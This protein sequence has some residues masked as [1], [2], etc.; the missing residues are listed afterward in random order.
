M[1]HASTPAA[2][3]PPVKRGKVSRRRWLRRTAGGAGLFGLWWTG[4]GVGWM[5]ATGL[6]RLAGWRVPF[7]ISAETTGVIEPLDAWGFPDYAAAFN[8]QKSAGVA[9]EENFEEGF[10]AVFGSAD[11]PVALVERYFRPPGGSVTAARPTFRKIEDV[12]PGR[13]EVD[14]A[15]IGDGDLVRAV[16]SPWT[17]VEL[18]DMATWLD[19]NRVALDQLVEAC[20]RPKSFLPCGSL[21]PWATAEASPMSLKVAWTHIADTRLAARLLRARAFRELSPGSYTR[22]VD[23]LLA[24][25]RMSRHVAADGFLI[26]LLVGFATEAIALDGIRALLDRPDWNAAELQYLADRLARFPAMPTTAQV[27]TTGERMYVLDSLVHI[28]RH[29]RNAEIEFDLWGDSD[30]LPR[31]A[32]MSAALWCGLDWDIVLRDAGKVLDRIAAVLATKSPTARKRDSAMLVHDLRQQAGLSKS[33]F[34]EWARPLVRSRT[35]TS[36][37]GAAILLGS[38]LPAYEQTAEAEGR[39]MAR[40]RM[41]KLAVALKR[42]RFERG[43]YPDRLESLDPKFGHLEKEDPALDAGEFQYRREGQ[44][45]VLTSEFTSL[46]EATDETAPPPRMSVRLVR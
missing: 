43:E 12:F 17:D 2:S 45:C 20:A 27:M 15:R 28:A 6:S 41:T 29:N 44:G 35:H 18:P 40:R 25:A 22:R 31:A 26:S 16:E 33:V 32:A 42:H 19:A 13:T 11:M 24:V 4:V 7:T 3:P 39:A 46:A 34:F 36:Q 9:P 5:R 37:R 8:A 21:D 14:R 10:H 23:D 38:V 30:R 1:S